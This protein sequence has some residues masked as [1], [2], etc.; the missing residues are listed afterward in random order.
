MIERAHL[1][2]DRAPAENR[3]PDRLVARDSPQ[4]VDLAVLDQI[5]TIGGVALPEQRCSGVDVERPRHKLHL[6]EF[7]RVE[8]REQWNLAQKIIEARVIH[9]NS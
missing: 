3:E 2:D 8:F 9:G 6:R 1:A 7:A 5:E 4:N